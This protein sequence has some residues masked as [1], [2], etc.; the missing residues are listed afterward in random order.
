[1]RWAGGLD[2]PTPALIVRLLHGPWRLNTCE[3]NVGVSV[4]F[5]SE[6]VVKRV[7]RTPF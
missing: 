2:N 1:V 7:T 5:S 4:E 6:N 3:S